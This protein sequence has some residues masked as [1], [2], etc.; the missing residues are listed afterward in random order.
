MIF[1]KLIFFSPSKTLT[2]Q[3]KIKKNRPRLFYLKKPKK[4][5]LLSNYFK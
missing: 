4:D 2:K 1:V 5:N 3:L